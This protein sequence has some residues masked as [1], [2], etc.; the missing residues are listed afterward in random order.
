MLLVAASGLSP[1]ARH[2][3]AYH[4]TDGFSERLVLGVCVGR[5]FPSNGTSE[6]CRSP[7]SGPS[8][9]IE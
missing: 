3:T 1:T 9:V 5:E 7:R 6:L 2:H 4:P 8:M